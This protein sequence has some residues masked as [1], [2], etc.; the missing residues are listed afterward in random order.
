MRTPRQLIVIGDS[1]V[2]GWGDREA[3]GW[4]ERLRRHWMGLPDAPLIY[5][6]GV[7]GDGLE[8]VSARWEREWMC[9]GEL[10]RKKPEAL[11][12]SVGLND[13]ARVGRSDGRQPLDA[14]ANNSGGT[15]S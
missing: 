4:C 9:R 15:T 5:G 8:A 10:R 3:G 11:L 12:L 2:V 1:G 14:Q 6:L 13:T 7:R